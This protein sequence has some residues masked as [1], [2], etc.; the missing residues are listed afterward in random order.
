MQDKIPVDAKDIQIGD[1][2]TL[3]GVIT[4]VYQ[5]RINNE[6]FTVRFNAC[7]SNALDNVVFSS[8]LSHPSAIIT[9][10]SPPL[11][12]DDR[13]RSIHPALGHY[14]Y[15]ILAISENRAWVRRQ[16]DHSRLDPY[17]YSVHKLDTLE[18]IE[19]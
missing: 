5:T 4:G 6:Q 13:V 18:R 7:E 1:E 8:V 17:D 14:E 12:V 16:H 10:K 11:Q 19:G 2:V 3:T 15:K 9:R